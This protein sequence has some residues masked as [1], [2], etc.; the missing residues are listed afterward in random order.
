MELK[1]LF[2]ISVLKTI[3]FNIHYFKI[4]GLKFPVLISKSTRLENLGGKVILNNVKSNKILI[5]FGPL[6]ASSYEKGYW[7]NN[8]IV[9]F[10][11]EAHIYSGA[12][13]YNNGKIIFGKNFRIGASKLF[14]ENFFQFGDD[15]MISWGCQIMDSDL[16]DIVSIENK[17][18]INIDGTV[19][20]GNHVWIAS[21]CNILKNTFISDDIIV[22]SNTFLTGVSLNLSNTIYG[23]HAKLI[24]EKVE[25]K[26]EH[27][28]Q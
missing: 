10:N 3:K 14:C 25:W 16:H 20:C 1:K 19:I 23:I 5:G 7:Y 6:Q 2:S 28:K 15:V 27:T 17:E 26:W 4:S 24:K 9:V 8:G 13:I 12:K 18:K 21:N 22:A 11:D